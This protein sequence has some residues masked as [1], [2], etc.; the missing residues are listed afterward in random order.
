M[1]KMNEKKKKKKKKIIQDQ[2][3]KVSALCGTPRVCCSKQST[4]HGMKRTW[5]DL[6]GRVFSDPYPTEMMCLLHE[7]T[8][9]WTTVCKKET[10]N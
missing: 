3:T 1:M 10:K 8:E 5:Q 6:L 7:E 4:R 9:L 2:K